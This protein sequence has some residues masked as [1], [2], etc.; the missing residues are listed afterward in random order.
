MSARHISVCICTFKRAELLTKLLTALQNQQTEGFFTY[1]IVIAD[2]DANRSA[3]IVARSFQNSNNPAIT[4]CVE[5]QQNIALVRNKAVQNASGDMIAFIDDD[6][7]PNDRW[8][9]NLFK[10]LET[11]SAAGIL[12]PVNPYFDPEPPAW[13]KKGKF[14]DRPDHGTGYK[15]NWPEARSGNVLFKKEIISGLD[16]PFRS[17]FNT[18]GEDVDFFCRMMEKGHVF[19]WCSEAAVHEVVPASRCTSSYML[20]R[21]LLRG[22]NFNKHP[23]HRVRNAIKSIIAVPAYTLALPVLAILG[24]HVFIKYLIKLFDHGARLFAYMG[25]PLITQRET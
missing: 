16:A 11:Y 19:I 14:F 25:V 10:A 21:A 9:L 5:P 15:L 12:G 4:Y 23:K 7:F 8:L 6:E 1:S 22:S 17:N 20:R 13:I 18:A 3:E 24:K 2:N